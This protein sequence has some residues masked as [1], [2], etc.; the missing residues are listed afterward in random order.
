MKRN[1]QT[2]NDM[3]EVVMFRNKVYRVILK[4]SSENKEKYVETWRIPIFSTT[5]T[6][7]STPR[8]EL[9]T[10]VLETYFAS[11]LKCQ[12]KNVSY[13]FKNKNYFRN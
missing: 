4:W 11:Q 1:V 7:L 2:I 10:R 6:S 12:N 3:N 5:N 8:L 13:N 9:E